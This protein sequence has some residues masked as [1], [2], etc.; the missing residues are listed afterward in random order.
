MQ[1]QLVLVAGCCICLSRG[2]FPVSFRRFSDSSPL[3]GGSGDGR[4]GAAVV[5]GW[6]QAMKIDFEIVGLPF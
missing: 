4:G 2:R 5:G 1:Q 3:E 6:A